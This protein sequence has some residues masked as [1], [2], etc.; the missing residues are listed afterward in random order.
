MKRKMIVAGGNAEHNKAPT[1]VSMNGGAII[2]G[3][4]KVYIG[5]IMATD[6]GAQTGVKEAPDESI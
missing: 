6:N 1:L 3:G 2:G 4:V 5:L